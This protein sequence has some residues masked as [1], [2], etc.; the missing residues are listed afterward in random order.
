MTKTFDVFLSYNGKDKEQV[1]LLSNALKKRDVLAWVD[2]G[3]IQG[4][5]KFLKEM[6][7]GI[8]SS[9]SIAVIVGKYG[10]GHFQELEMEM[11]LVTQSVIIPVW[12]PG[13]PELHALPSYLITHS[14]IDLRYAQ[15]TKGNEFESLL[16]AIKDAKNLINRSQNYRPNTLQST[17]DPPNE[18]YT[19]KPPDRLGQNKSK[20]LK[21]FM[22]LF[23]VVFVVLIALVKQPSTDKTLNTTIDDKKIDINNNG[24]QTVSINPRPS[25]TELSVTVNGR[26]I[27]ECQTSPCEFKAPLNAKVKYTA[28]SNGQPIKNGGFTVASENFYE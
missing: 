16:T 25:G 1:T 24:F 26:K 28:F 15:L 6:D 5:D 20:K 21:I 23:S 18:L 12:L 2:K 3:Q 10:F 8:K 13:C 27:S 14:A 17:V 19:V 4:G 22:L 7:R 9:C 11:A